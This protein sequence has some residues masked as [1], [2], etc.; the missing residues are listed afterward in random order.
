MKS[1]Y[2]VNLYKLKGADA[3]MLYRSSIENKDKELLPPFLLEI[4]LLAKLLTDFISTFNELRYVALRGSGP[5]ICESIHKHLMTIAQSIVN[6]E[7]LVSQIVVP[8]ARSENLV[9]NKVGLLVGT[10]S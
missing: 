4:P 10:N 9:S 5:K 2:S 1:I 6:A 8:K 3:L 7:A